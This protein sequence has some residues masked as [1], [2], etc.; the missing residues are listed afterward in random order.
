MIMK[1]ITYYLIVAFTLI[2]TSFLFQS[3][4]EL[5]GLANVEVSYEFEPVNFEVEIDEAMVE[6]YKNIEANEAITLYEDNVAMDIDSVLNAYDLDESLIKDAK[7][8]YLQIN[9]ADEREE[10][11]FNFVENFK[12]ELSLD[13]TNWEE[14]AIADPIPTNSKTL[15]FNLS[16]VFIDQYID[17]ENLNFRIVGKASGTP[18]EIGIM[19]FILNMGM[20]FTANPLSVE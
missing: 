4:E 12:F 11:N 13:G 16:D 14:I 19:P 20:T 17:Y 1:K 15:D 9:I 2:G 3:C 5:G 8:D 18:P 7:I 6:T 10:L